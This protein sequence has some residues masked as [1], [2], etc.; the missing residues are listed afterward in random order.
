M[1]GT[2]HSREG[3]MKHL[4][5]II[6]AL[7]TLFICADSPLRARELPLEVA[8][9]TAAENAFE[10][11]AKEFEVQAAKWSTWNVVANYLPRVQ[12][13]G[14][15]MRMDEE[16][17]RWA[18]SAYDFMIEAILPPGTPYPE[19]PNRLFVDSFSHE[20]S[21]SQPVSNGGAEIIAIRIARHVRE[22]VEMNRQAAVQEAIYTTREAYFNALAAGERTA[23]ETQYLGWAKKNLRKSRTRVQEGAAPVT[24]LL[25]WEAE[26][27]QKESDLLTARATERFMILS[28]YHSMGVTPAE[29]DTSVNL[30][31]LDVFEQWYA[32]GPIPAD[33]AVQNN[34]QLRSVI[35]YTEAAKA[36][37]NLTLT[38]FLPRLNAFYLY[39]W[40]AW[41]RL[42]PWDE[43]KGWT[44]GLSLTIP[45][46]SGFRNTTSYKKSTYEYRKAVVEEAQIKGQLELNLERIALLYAASFKEVEAAKK[47]MELMDR[48]LEI[49]QKRYDGGLV[50]QLELLETALGARQTRIGYL[51]SLFKYLLLEAEYLKNT[52]RL[53]V[54]R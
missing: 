44:A 21:V 36:Q 42:E 24:D 14:N 48:Q 1:R 45:V 13:T 31:S 39:S 35:S 8:E 29:A 50:N 37:K 23:V 47:S 4:P 30:A 9:R 32:R 2:P 53:E 51:Q 46:F 26:V 12:Y 20:I 52:G 18:N 16:T 25:R 17:V 7:L 27:L 15:Y 11:A 19:N 10:A 34:P 22:A 33:G 6:S 43:R 3:K 54:A 49:M 28:L 41:D 5:I 38:Q 40:P